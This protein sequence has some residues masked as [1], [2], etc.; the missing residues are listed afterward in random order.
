M[1]AIGFY[2]SGTMDSDGDGRLRS[3]E[4]VTGRVTEA[5]TVDRQGDP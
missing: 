2:T 5:F 3:R 1:I 4:R